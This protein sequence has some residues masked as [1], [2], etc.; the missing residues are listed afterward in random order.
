MDLSVARGVW[1]AVVV[2]VVLGLFALRFAR[3]R[4]PRG[5]LWYGVAGVVIWSAYLAIE[6]RTVAARA[7]TAGG[8]AAFTLFVTVLPT[9]V[10]FL[11]G[12]ALGRARRLPGWLAVALSIVATLVV[13]VLFTNIGMLFID[14]VEA[15][16]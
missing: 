4:L 16:G 15:V 13:C 6:L 1:I 12:L 9:V 8:A 11:I 3:E 14:M 5:R 2:P 10:S 7:R